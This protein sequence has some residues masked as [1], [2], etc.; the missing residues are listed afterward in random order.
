MP[1]LT[2]YRFEIALESKYTIVSFIA[3]LSN[4]DIGPPGQFRP[5]PLHF[6]RGGEPAARA[7]EYG[8]QGV[9]ERRGIRGSHE[10]LDFCA[11]RAGAFR[12]EHVLLESSPNLRIEE[13]GCLPLPLHG[14][15]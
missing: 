9:R 5:S 11:R 12:A 13:E 2:S 3:F 14:V 15:R 6:F 1:S 4:Q 7:R 8:R 10:P